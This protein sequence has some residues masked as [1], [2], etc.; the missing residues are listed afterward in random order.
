LRDIVNFGKE[1][2]VYLNSKAPWHLIKKD[3]NAAGHV[4]NICAQAVYAFGIL[5]SP[6]IPG[7]AEKVLSYLNISM[8][9]DLAWDSINENSVKEGLKIKK[10][11]PLFQKLD[12]QEIEDK[13]QKLKEQKSKVGGKELVSYEDF[14]KLDIRVAYVESVE[15]VP[16]ADKLYKLS[17]TLG[18]EKRTLVAGLAE[19][20]KVDELKG[21]KVVILANLEPRK[22]RG[23]LSEGM[24]LAAVDGD[25]VSVLTPDKNIPP[26]AKIE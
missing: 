5:L 3:K 9:K 4:F 10:P 12:V 26:G 19:H 7:T 23:I 18:T 1:G 6:F 8:S 17:I 20:Y 2:N 16:K 21:K 13:L 25:V 15:K 24:L 22:L 14:K 11:E